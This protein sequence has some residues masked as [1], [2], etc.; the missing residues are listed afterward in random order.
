MVGKRLDQDQKFILEK[1]AVPMVELGEFELEVKLTGLLLQDGKQ[2]V[3]TRPVSGMVAKLWADQLKAQIVTL[4]Y[5][6]TYRPVAEE[7]E[8]EDDSGNDH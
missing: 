1:Q 4:D 3:F 8:D 2:V 5:I 7:S 6:A